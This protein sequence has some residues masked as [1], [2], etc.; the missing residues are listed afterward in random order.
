MAFPDDYRRVQQ[1]GGTKAQ[2]ESTEGLPRQILIDMQNLS[3]RLMDG[4]KLGGHKFAMQDEI[5]GILQGGAGP[6]GEVDYIKDQVTHDPENPKRLWRS[7]KLRAVFQMLAD[8]T[9][10]N[11]WVVKDS[12]MPVN[13]RAS[14]TL[15]ADLNTALVNGF[16]RFVPNAAMNI[17]AGLAGTNQYMMSVIRQSSSELTQIVFSRAVDG[18]IWI[19]SRVGGVFQAWT[20]ATGVTAADLLLKVDKAGDTMSGKLT[21]PVSTNVLAQLNLRPGVSP[22]TPS[23]GDI[24]RDDTNGGLTLRKGGVTANI[25]DSKRKF[26]TAVAILS[27]TKAQ[28]AAGGLINPSVWTVRDIN[29]ENYDPHNIVSLTSNRF[30]LAAGSD[31]ILSVSASGNQMSGSSAYLSVMRIFNVTDVVPV[32][33]LNTQFN[34]NANGLSGQHSLQ[35]RLIGGKTYSIEHWRGGPSAVQIGIISNLAGNSEV[36]LTMMIMRLTNGFE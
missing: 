35:A 25:I 11:N 3:P 1:A 4:I 15:I 34:A 12:A 8:M 13:L 26:E 17:P 20:L 18:K 23:D 22:S 33:C 2:V 16:Y 31:Y 9:D 19:R 27:D 21:L 29:T 5:P 32:Q 14:A 10:V 6:E 24:W 30:T 36:Y 7:S 28:G